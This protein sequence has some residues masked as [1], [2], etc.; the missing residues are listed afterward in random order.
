MVA[1]GRRVLVPEHEQRADRRAVHQLD[2]RLEDRDARALGPGQRRGDVEAALGQQLV[3]VVARDSPR[4]LRVA[5]ADAV[6]V[7]LG[8]RRGAAERAARGSAGPVA[9]DA[10]PLAAVGQH[11][12][13]DH[14]VGGQRPGAVELGHHRVHAAGVV[15]DHPA[16]R[17]VRSAS[18]DR[19]RR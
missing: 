8:E 10:Q 4:D 15:A 13:L 16:E 14:L 7:A 1:G 11:V 2:R 3:E 9:A 12:E 17:A 19:A 5:L 6:A 18:T